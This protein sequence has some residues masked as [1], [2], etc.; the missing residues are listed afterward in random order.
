V[1]EK[2][3]RIDAEFDLGAIPF[4]CEPADVEFRW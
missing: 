4:A 1:R 2:K 3:I